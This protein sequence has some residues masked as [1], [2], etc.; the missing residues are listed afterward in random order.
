MIRTATSKC[1]AA[2]SFD[3]ATAVLPAGIG[4]TSGVTP[5]P[6]DSTPKEP[7][8][9]FGGRCSPRKINS[10]K[11][12]NASGGKSPDFVC[13][14]KIFHARQKPFF[15]KFTK[16]CKHLSNWPKTHVFGYG[17]KIVSIPP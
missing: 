1:R 7:S 14:K 6:T 4:P 2:A 16:C 5:V 9:N 10:Q 11:A 12:F 15:L 8:R 3:P 13:M 17:K